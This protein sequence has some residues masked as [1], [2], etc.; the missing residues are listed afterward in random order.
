MSRQYYPKGSVQTIEEFLNSFDEYAANGE[1]VLFI[2][3][4]STG[5]ISTLFI[6]S[7]MIV[8]HDD[9]EY[10]LGNFLFPILNLAEYNIGRF[11]DESTFMFHN[12][13][14]AK[15]FLTQKVSGVY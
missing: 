12:M 1:A 3:N 14:H 6:D 2:A 4:G 13:L 11:T 15:Q 5:E 8:V 7:S 9:G 10:I